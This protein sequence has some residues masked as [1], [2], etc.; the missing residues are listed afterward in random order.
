MNEINRRKILRENEK[1]TLS[2]L[3]AGSLIITLNLIIDILIGD[4][5]AIA[6]FTITSLPI[7]IILFIRAFKKANLY[8]PKKKTK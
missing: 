4:I 5:S 2:F 7:V 3:A 8:I 6:A 1:D